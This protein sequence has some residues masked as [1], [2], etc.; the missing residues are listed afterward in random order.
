[1]R[2]YI[3]CTLGV[4][5]SLMFFSCAPKSMYEQ[6]VRQ[7]AEEAGIPLIQVAYAEGRKTLVFEA[8]ANPEI[9]ARED[10]GTVFQAAS[11]SKPVF[12][13][14]V[15]KMAHEGLMDLD[16]PLVTYTNIERFEDKEAA[17]LLTA[18]MVLH[19]VTGLPNW[20]AGPGSEVWP[21]SVISFN[22][23]PGSAFS[24]SGEGFSF[25]QRAVEAVCGA[26]LEQIAREQ[27]FDPL[28][29]DRTSYVWLPA[30]D[31]LAADG[32]NREG[33]STGKGN[34]PRANA[35]YTLRTTAADYMKFLKHVSRGPLAEQ[36]WLQGM[37]E[38]KVQAVRYADKPRECDKTV[39]WGLGMGIE[40]HPELGQV[41]F[42]WG[43]NGNFKALFLMVPE[44][45]M[46]RERILV[47]LTNSRAGHDIVES[48]SSLFLGNTIPVT[49]HDWINYGN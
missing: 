17:G 31:S 13:Y 35:A 4:L 6:Q 49:I 2:K 44:S 8:S 16:A 7:L 9:Q 14:I 27:V 19:H 38:P 45:T 5:I 20:A 39:F 46:H 15:L 11:L 34:F 40:K 24:Y 26:D 12:A 47:Y 33:E 29:M 48:I 3:N 22:R 43:D 32:F 1:M 37:F 30:F 28:G 18:R 21:L 10:A 41:A 42:H 25:L 36:E 23:Q